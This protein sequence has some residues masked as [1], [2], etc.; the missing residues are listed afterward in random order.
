MLI[1]VLQYDFLV[2]LTQWK[3][4]QQNFQGSF[5]LKCF[6]H[7]IKNCKPDQ[8]SPSKETVHECT[9]YV[10]DYSVQG[11]CSISPN[12]LGTQEIISIY[13]NKIHVC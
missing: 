3:V 5:I 8:N 4:C 2:A 9:V 12:L 13:K 11:L 6:S 7:F 1:A 10:H